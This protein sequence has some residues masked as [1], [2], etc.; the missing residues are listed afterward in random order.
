M[1]SS[2][3][4]PCTNS[5]YPGCP[6]FLT[7]RL[8]TV[9]QVCTCQSVY[10]ALL[11]TRESLVA[12]QKHGGQPHLLKA[13]IDPAFARAPRPPTARP[14]TTQP[15]QTARAWMVADTKKCCCFR[16]SSL[17]W[18]VRSSGYSTEDSV[19]ARCRDRI[20]C[21]QGTQRLE[22][23]SSSPMCND[24]PPSAVTHVRTYTGPLHEQA[25]QATASPHE[26]GE[27]WSGHA[28]S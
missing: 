13:P 21:V 7:A 6:K 18:N 27:T 24:A 16:R 15:A 1:S 2:P 28:G 12:D 22:T 5:V 9:S 10:K 19:S 4:S 26:G 25:M 8:F 14:P 3:P 11:L 17:P 20:A 23:L